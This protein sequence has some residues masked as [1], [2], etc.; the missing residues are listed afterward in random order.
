MTGI[1]EGY[2]NVVE[3]GVGFSG[4]GGLVDRGGSPAERCGAA[5]GIAYL[6]K[7]KLM[8]VEARVNDGT[9]EGEEIEPVPKI[10]TRQHPSGDVLFLFYIG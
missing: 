4:I 7:L 9:G 6:Y 5:K 3:R 8:I 1:L 10:N 2:I